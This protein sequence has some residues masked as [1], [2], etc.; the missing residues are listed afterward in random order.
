MEE[1][2]ISVQDLYRK[3][4]GFTLVWTGVCLPLTYWFGIQSA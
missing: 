3:F 1:N 4:S 2:N